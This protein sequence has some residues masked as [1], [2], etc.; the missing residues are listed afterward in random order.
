MREHDQRAELWRRIRTRHPRL[1]EALRADA[2]LATR[3][4]G[5]PPPSD[6]RWRTIVAVVRLAWVSDAFLGQACYRA[7]AR[8]Q[9]LGI[10]VL[11]RIAHR[12][13]MIS[14]QIAI[15]DPVV[16]ESGVYIIHGQ[17][18]IDGLTV[19]ESGV[20]IAP[21]VTIG[22]RAGDLRGPT[23]GAGASIGAG[24]QVIGPVRVG[25]NAVIG[26]GAVVVADVPPGATVVGTPARPL[27][28]ARHAPD[29]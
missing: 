27:S 16:V 19:V 15:G 25:A 3:L 18:V 11:P 2:Q 4:R 23:I 12:L 28:P 21:F 29:R 8:L 9:A 17:V 13:A 6:S 20:S 24:A 14:A 26:A 5:E 1:G 22:L 10:P 7:K